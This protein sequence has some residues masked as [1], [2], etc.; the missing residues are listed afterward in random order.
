MRFT[1]LRARGT[2]LVELAREEEVVDRV[3]DKVSDRLSEDL[4]GLGMV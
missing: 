1:G 4:A 2:L 3:G